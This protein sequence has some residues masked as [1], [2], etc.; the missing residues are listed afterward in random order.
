MPDL[1][2]TSGEYTSWLADLK[3][4]I[5]TAQQRA[6]FSFNPERVLLSWQNGRD[7]LERQQARG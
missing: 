5:Q 3:H 1:A 4:R 6:T 7:I 2:I